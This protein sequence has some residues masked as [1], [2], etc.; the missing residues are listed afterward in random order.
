MDKNK[1]ESQKIDEVKKI[2]EENFLFFL[3][4]NSEGKMR[5]SGKKY[6]CSNCG[7]EL[8]VYLKA[9]PEEAK[10]LNIVEFHI[11][12]ENLQIIDEVKEIKKGEY[13]FKPNKIVED[14][15]TSPNQNFDLI[16]KIRSQIKN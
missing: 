16:S 13:K 11:C 8:R 12:T 6:Y 1:F 14:K 4:K 3:N 9:V 2:C 10:I 15:I 5:N 7:K